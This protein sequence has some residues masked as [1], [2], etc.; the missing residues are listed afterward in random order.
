MNIRQSLELRDRIVSRV[1]EALYWSQYLHENHLQLNDRIIAALDSEPTCKRMPR[2]IR[3]YITGYVAAKRE[4]I[5]RTMIYGVWL[6]GEFY[7]ATTRTSPE[8]V[9]RR[10]LSWRE[11]GEI[12]RNVDALVGHWYP[13]DTTKPWSS[14]LSPNTR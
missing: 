14:N 5:E 12:G 8:Y 11:F 9:E 2:W 13:D 7:N 3:E 6:D 4:P 10:G 1:N